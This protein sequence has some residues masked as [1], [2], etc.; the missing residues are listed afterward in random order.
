MAG[1]ILLPVTFFSSVLVQPVRTISG[2]ALFAAISI[3]MILVSSRGIKPNNTL[4]DSEYGVLIFT[5]FILGITVLGSGYIFVGT[6][7]KTNSNINN[8]RRLNN[9][10]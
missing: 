9:L 2:I 4:L 3:F 5:Y 10:R 1:L 7:L 6:F 8:N